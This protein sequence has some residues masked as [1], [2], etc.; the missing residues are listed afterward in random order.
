MY[1]RKIWKQI[2]KSKINASACFWM[3]SQNEE[4]VEHWEV[5]VEGTRI[6]DLLERVLPRCS[7]KDYIPIW[8]MGKYMGRLSL[9]S[10][11]EGL[12]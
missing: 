6:R 1:G 5:R 2:K 12:D 10:D 7:R 3:G 11:E 8:E 9:K 4:Q